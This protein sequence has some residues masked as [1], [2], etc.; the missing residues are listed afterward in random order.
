MYGSHLF[1]M[2]GALSFVCTLLVLV[3]GVPEGIR[4]LDMIRDA[5]RKAARHHKEGS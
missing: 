2:A 4:V 1:H 3:F 5:L